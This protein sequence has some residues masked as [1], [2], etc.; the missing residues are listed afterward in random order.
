[1]I[2]GLISGIVTLA[3]PVVLII[4]AVRQFGS[5]GGNQG[6][7]ARS[8]RR[9]FQYLLL[10]ALLIVAAVGLADLLG[11]LSREPALVSDD[12]STLARTLTFTFVGLPIYTVL[13]LWSRRTLRADSEERSALGWAFYATVA[14]LTALVVAMFALFEVVADALAGPRLDWPALARL[15]VW[16]AVWLV[17]RRLASRTLDE[18]RLQG[19]LVIGAFIGLGTAIAGTVWLLGASIDALLVEPVA[20]VLVRT[21]P[22]LADAAAT[23]VVGV[24]VWALYWIKGFANAR[25]NTLWFAYVLLVGVGGSLVLA[26][27]GGSI[28]LYQTLV[29]FLGDPAASRALQHFEGTP[30]AGALVVV[31]TLSWWYHRQALVGATPERTEVTR[32]YEYLMAGIALIAAAVGVAMVLVA[33]LEAL[34]PAAVVEVGTSPKNSLLGGVTLLLVGSPLWWVFWSRIT[35][36]TRQEGL[37]E[38]GSPTRRI[39]LFVLFGLVGVAAVVAVLVAAFLGI[40]GVLQDGF[41]AQVLHS[42]RVALAILV[43]AGAVSGY[44]WSIYRDDRSR[45]PAPTPPRGPRYVLLL[46]APDGVVAGA[47]HRLTGARVEQWVRADGQAGPWVVEDVVAAVNESGSEAVA[48]VAGPSGLEPIALQRG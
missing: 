48:I 37:E 17:H 1:V 43:T 34:L 28:V 40:Q 15:I 46:G 36:A 14:P 22:Q 21:P 33:F 9:F 38:L 27:V 41:D 39:Y 2:L 5:R 7:D 6:L 47:V 12:G 23:M 8:V 31:G 26:V 32:I 24:P 16:A 13:A 4:W 10:Y 44:H 11:M 29:W 45:T 18:T 20:D 3:I 35:R 42:M 30:T 25:R 19:Q